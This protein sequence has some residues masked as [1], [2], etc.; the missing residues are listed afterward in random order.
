VGFVSLYFSANADLNIGFPNT[1]GGQEPPD[2]ISGGSMLVARLVSVEGKK[3]WPLLV[4]Y[5][6]A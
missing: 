4:L 1:L 6:S 2:L 3:K 5:I